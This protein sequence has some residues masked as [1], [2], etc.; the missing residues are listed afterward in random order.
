MH[1]IALPAAGQLFTFR[2]PRTWRHPRPKT[3]GGHILACEEELGIAHVRVIS[4][5]RWRIAHMVILAEEVAPFITR[6][7]NDSSQVSDALPSILKWRDEHRRGESGAFAVPLGRAI[8]LVEQAVA[9]REAGKSV[10]NLF[11]EAAYPVR[12][13][14][15]F[16]S[17]L[18][19]IAR[20]ESR[21]TEESA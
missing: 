14:D 1:Q 20:E 11:V 15:G 17:R 10:Q 8:E 12:G 16:F 19:V 6:R 4:N 7:H 5:D 9:E 2:W 3:G 18:C 21:S 13:A